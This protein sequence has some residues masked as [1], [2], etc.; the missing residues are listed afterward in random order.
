MASRWMYPWTWLWLVMQT[1]KR[2]PPAVFTRYVATAAADRQRQRQRQRS[3]SVAR[4]QGNW[5][6]PMRMAWKS[7]V[8]FCSS[9]LWVLLTLSSAWS[10]TVDA[11]NI[12][13]PAAEQVT[14]Q[15]QEPATSEVPSPAAPSPAYHNEWIRGR[16]VWL[17]DAFEKQFGITTVPEV[18]EHNLAILTP[19][20]ALLPLVEN[21][22]GRA[23]RKD[24]QLRAMELEILARRYEKQPFV[25]IVKIV[26]IDGDQRFE[27]DYWCDVCAIIMF[28]KG[29]CAC[30]QDENRLRRRL[31]EPSGRNTED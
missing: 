17:A 20:G 2:T 21:L 28:E 7:G 4:N 22:R 27:I 6:G 1:S 26:E 3:R 29:P 24:P 15:E 23:F 14:S 25:Q 11:S 16:V 8:G 10:Q 9:Y 5:P 31:V 13:Q 12:P 30:C 19:D 18:A